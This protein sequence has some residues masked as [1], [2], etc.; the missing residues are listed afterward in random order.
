MQFE[1]QLG[2]HK[3]LWMKNEL[4]ADLLYFAPDGTPVDSSSPLTC[5]IWSES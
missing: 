5:S 1:T 2:L 4:P 3:R